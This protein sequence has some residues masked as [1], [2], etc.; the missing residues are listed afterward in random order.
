M[1]TEEGASYYTY[2]PMAGEEVEAIGMDM[3]EG[4]YIK[5]NG[6]ITVDSVEQGLFPY[7]SAYANQYVNSINS[8]AM[9][10]AS[11]KYTWAKG[12]Y[13]LP[14][15]KHVLTDAITGKPFDT[16]EIQPWTDDNNK[17]HW[18]ITSVNAWQNNVSIVCLPSVFLSEEDATRA[19][20]IKIAID[21]Y[22]S[23][24]TAKF[25]VGE[26]PLEELDDY[27]EAL[28]KLNIEEYIDIYRT[29]YQTYMDGIFGK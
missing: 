2:G 22:V 8:P 29:A 20:D 9:L 23:A 11:N 19:N 17:G 1:Y 10:H 27:F 5:E 4:W 12:G 15:T 26:R 24:E 14:Y 21:T 6:D 7:F 28:R 25:V 16:Y 13:D 3:C 18:F